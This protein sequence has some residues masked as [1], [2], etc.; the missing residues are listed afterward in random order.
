MVLELL[1]RGL[2]Q[3][4]LLY[5]IGCEREKHFLS[6]HLPKG[7]GYT[8]GCEREKHL[9]SANVNIESMNYSTVMTNTSKYVQPTIPKFD[10]HYDHWA[11]L[12]EN[13]LRSKEFWHLVKNGIV[14][15]SK[16]ANAL[17][18]EIK[19]MEEQKLKDPKIKNYL[20]QVIDREILDTILNDNT[21]KNIWDSMK[22][23]FQGSTRVVP[24]CKLC[25]KTLNYFK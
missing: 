7:V 24:N 15:I 9:L 4:K 19:L 11:K 16:K 6:E 5:E 8:R 2:S 22:Q 10:G 23:K 12:M 20:Y 25:A 17:E 1:Y 18:E 14:D 21:S 3:K 13:F